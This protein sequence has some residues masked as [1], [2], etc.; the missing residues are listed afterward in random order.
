M[1]NSSMFRRFQAAAPSS[2]H[3]TDKPR[4]E[5][6]VYR[7]RLGSEKGLSFERVTLRE[8]ARKAARARTAEDR[9]ETSPALKAQIKDSFDAYLRGDARPVDEFLAELEAELNEQ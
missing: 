6:K 7:I 1:T 2:A 5:V 9:A 8:L 3:G 4:R